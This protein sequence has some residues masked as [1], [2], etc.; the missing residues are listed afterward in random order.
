L[1]RQ[2]IARRGARDVGFGR[3]HGIDHV[4]GVFELLQLVHD[5]EADF[6]MMSVVIVVGKEHCI[7]MFIFFGVVPVFVVVGLR[8]SK[9]VGLL[10]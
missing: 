1:T 9:L 7:L 5:A 10:N 8:T 2:N 4:E 3:E 6:V